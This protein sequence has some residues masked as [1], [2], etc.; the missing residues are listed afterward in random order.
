MLGDKP[1]IANTM[2]LD[3]RNEDGSGV[4]AGLL[5]TLGDIGEDGQA[6]MLGAS[7]LGVGATN[8]LGAY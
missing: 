5:D 6:E 8:N 7:L 2:G 4:G 1:V 3:I